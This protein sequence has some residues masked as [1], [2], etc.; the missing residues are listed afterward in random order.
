M[1]LSGETIT[2]LA[3]V[4]GQERSAYCA[5]GVCFECLVEIDHLPNQLACLTEVSEGMIVKRQAITETSRL[6][7]NSPSS[8][9]ASEHAE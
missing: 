1:A 2:R 3:P 5:M 8:P 9:Q 4:T 7:E 6:E